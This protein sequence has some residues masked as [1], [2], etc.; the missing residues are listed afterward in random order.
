MKLIYSAADLSYLTTFIIALHL[1][2]AIEESAVLCRDFIAVYCT[3]LL[4]FE[5]LELAAVAADK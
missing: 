3:I 5:K 4:E 2:V 1:L